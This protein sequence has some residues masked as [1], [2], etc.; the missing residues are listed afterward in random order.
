MENN[1]I[2][3]RLGLTSPPP[4]GQVN[5]SSGHDLYCATVYSMI[6]TLQPRNKRSKLHYPLVKQ[7]K[8]H[9]GLSKM[10]AEMA[11][12]IDGLTPCGESREGISPTKFCIESRYEMLE[13]KVMAIDQTLR[14]RILQ[15]FLLLFLP[16][17]TQLFGELCALSS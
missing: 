14:K 1:D 11:K 9:V 10:L 2:K 7:S 8:F 13:N 17:V 4:I 16:E 12:N 3:I 6:T 15:I 5:T